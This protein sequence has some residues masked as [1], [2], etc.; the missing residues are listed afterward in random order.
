[1]LDEFRLGDKYPDADYYWV[2]LSPRKEQVQQLV[3]NQRTA[4]EDTIASLR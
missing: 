4:L 2:V 3:A 1:M